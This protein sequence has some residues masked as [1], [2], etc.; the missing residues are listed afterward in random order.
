MFQVPWGF[1]PVGRNLVEECRDNLSSVYPLVDNEVK[2]LDLIL[3]KGEIEP[4]LLTADAGLQGRIKQHPVLQWKAMN[5][6]KH[7]GIK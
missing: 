7:L 3:N 5:V 1:L 6:R 4:S 2:F